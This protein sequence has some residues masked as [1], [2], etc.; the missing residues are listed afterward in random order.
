MRTAV[1]S[2]EIPLR[3]RRGW[4]LAH[5]LRDPVPGVERLGRELTLGPV[6][7]G[8]GSTRIGHHVMAY[9][10]GVQCRVEPG[11]V[12]G[13]DARVVPAKQR[14]DR[15]PDQVAPIPDRAVTGGA[16]GLRHPVEPDGP[17]KTM[18]MS[19]GTPGDVATETESDGVDPHAGIPVPE[20]PNSR[21][22]VGIQALGGGPGDVL[23]I[24]EVGISLFDPGGATEVVDG[25]RTVPFGSKATGKVFVELEETP[26]VGENDYRG[27]GWLCWLCSQRVEPVPVGSLEYQVLRNRILYT[28]R[29]GRKFSIMI[30]TH[31]AIFAESHRSRHRPAVMVP[32]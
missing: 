19:G 3:Y 10:S 13:R 30:H 11:D 14:E 2:S 20:I 17:R 9:T 7:E 16:V 22:D 25:H 29:E 8:V 26:N 15:A 23:H 31:R 27:T 24:S 5:E 6:E 1:K 32:C 4:V 12:L 18:I 21:S 28:G